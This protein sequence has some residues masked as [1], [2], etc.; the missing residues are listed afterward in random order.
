MDE[1]ILITVD[2]GHLVDIDAVAEG[3]RAAGMTV[4]RVLGTIGVITGLAS[5]ECRPALE[6]VPGV[7]AVEAD[8]KYQIPPPDADVQ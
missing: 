4:E 1:R 2:E 8:Q 6:H 7:M 3:L 5:S